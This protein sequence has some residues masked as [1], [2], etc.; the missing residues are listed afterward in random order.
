MKTIHIL[1]HTKNGTDGKELALSLSQ[2]LSEHG[3]DV[4]EYC[5]NSHPETVEYINTVSPA[6]CQLI[7]TVN[8][9]GFDAVTT[10][11]CTVLNSLPMNIVNCI[12]AEPEQWA[13]C[14]KNRINY[15]MS[16]LVPSESSADYIR[17]SFPHIYHV[18]AAESLPDFLPGYLET[19]DWRY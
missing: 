7:I 4:K 9:A 15:T 8:L 19:M 2:K 17:T 5:L 16:F 1:Y 18:C 10:E 3:Y 6:S 11:G 12:T 13:D 14:L